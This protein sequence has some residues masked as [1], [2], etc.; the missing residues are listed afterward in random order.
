MCECV[1]ECDCVFVSVCNGFVCL[2]L[3]VYLCFSCVYVL[4]CVCACVCACAC[5]CVIVCVCVCVCVFL[6]C[7]CA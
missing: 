1:I 3:C 2:R 7:V 5:V 4:V 6:L